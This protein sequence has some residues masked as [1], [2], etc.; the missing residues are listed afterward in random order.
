[1]ETRKE[2]FSKR[3]NFILTRIGSYLFELSS[4]Y[5]QKNELYTKI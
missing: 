1:M 3:Y 2:F 4:S 5:F